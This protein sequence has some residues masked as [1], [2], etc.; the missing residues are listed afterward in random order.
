MYSNHGSL[1]FRS[2]NHEGKLFCLNVLGVAE[3]LPA[4]Q[5]EGSN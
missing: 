5:G 4:V 3:H 2:A 1:D